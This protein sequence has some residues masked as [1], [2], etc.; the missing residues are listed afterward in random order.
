MDTH[1]VVIG[2]GTSGSMALWQLA[3]RGVKV[4]GVEQFGIGHA[5]GSYAGDSR[6]FRSTVHEGPRY[7][8][9]LRRARE[10]WRELE[11]RTGRHL[12]D[13]CG[14]LQIGPAGSGSLAKSL[15]C[16]EQF[17]LPHEVLD[18][19]ALRARYPQHHIDAD[20][21]AA[22]LDLHAGSLYPEAGVFAAVDAAKAAGAQVL[23]NTEVLDFD[24]QGGRLKLI[25]S[26]E[27]ITCD[28]VV[29]A[30]GSWTMRLRPDLRGYLH[31][32]PFALTW[33]MPHHPEMFTPERFPVFI[34]DS[35]GVHL[36]GTPTHDSYS[37]K[38]AS[39]PLWSAVTDPD[40][41]PVFGRPE[42]RTIG[43]WAAHYL[44][45]LN[46]EP[47]RYSMHH[48][49]CAPGDFPI[50]DIDEDS[51]MLLLTAFSGRGYKFAPVYGEL[52]ANLIMGEHNDLYDPGFA[53]SE[54]AR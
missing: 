13:E 16:A 47:V 29:V 20:D 44:P 37:V 32:L 52:A 8:P 43:R 12:Y 11:A 27:A 50:I 28:K 15:A 24:E 35:D 46:P 30:T 38:V 10:L 17:D 48:D 42:L 31:V 4:V 36:Y 9:L 53:L 3:E 18:A 54:H 49:L 7:V 51:G 41:I 2:L 45:D 23:T 14:A 5:R 34:R 21:T 25:T 6:L 39:D 33:F 26:G 40:E 1:V 19:D 22:V